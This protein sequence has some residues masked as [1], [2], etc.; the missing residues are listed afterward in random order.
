[1]GG[2]TIVRSAGRHSAAAVATAMAGHTLRSLVMDAQLLSLQDSGQR[3]CGAT[4][5][6]AVQIL[7]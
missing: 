5:G 4:A 2:S 3:W 7:R 6:K 1:M